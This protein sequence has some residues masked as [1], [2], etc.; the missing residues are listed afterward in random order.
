MDVPPGQYLLESEKMSEGA[1]WVTILTT[2]DLTKAATVQGMLQENGI[3][4]RFFQLPP[5]EIQVPSDQAE[6]ARA[7]LREWGLTP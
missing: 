1:D 4:V 5:C 7:F 3:E 2:S 6:P